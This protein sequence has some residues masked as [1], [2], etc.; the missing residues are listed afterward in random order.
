MVRDG[1]VDLRAADSGSGRPSNCFKKSGAPGGAY[2]CNHP[3]ECA[4]P[5][6]LASPQATVLER[7]RSPGPPRRKTRRRS[8][9]ILRGRAHRLLVPGRYYPTCEHLRPSHDGL[10]PDG[11][12]V[13]RSFWLRQ[14]GAEGRWL[15]GRPLLSAHALAL[16]HRRTRAAMA[17]STAWSG[18]GAIGCGPAGMAG[19]RQ[20]S[21]YQASYPPQDV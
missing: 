21:A 13:K 14:L 19:R 18:V 17:R 8:C 16:R 20:I 2:G 12:T 11:R 3:P 5:R 9:R 4:C 7:P 1:C 15:K 6:E 10:R